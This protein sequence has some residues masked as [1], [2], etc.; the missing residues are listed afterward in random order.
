MKIYV[1]STFEDLREHRAA[2]DTALRRMGH[3]VIGIKHYVA[4]GTT[5]L[6]RCLT[7]VRSADVYIVIIA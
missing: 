2:L 5:P 3:D 1:S 7:D 6:K 4:E